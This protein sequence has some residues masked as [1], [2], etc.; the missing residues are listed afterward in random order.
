MSWNKHLTNLCIK[1]PLHLKDVPALRW[2]IWSDRLSRKRNNY[3]HILMNHC[4]N[5]DKQGTDDRQYPFWLF[6]VR[7]NN[8]C[9][10]A[11]RMVFCGLSFR[12]RTS[13]SKNSNVISCACSARSLCLEL[14]LPSYIWAYQF[15]QASSQVLCVSNFSVE[16]LAETFVNCNLLAALSS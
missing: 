10:L 9:C 15:L 5:S 3:V 2:E 6:D 1:Y 16:I 14:F 12:L 11:N 13:S 8:G 7:W 4:L